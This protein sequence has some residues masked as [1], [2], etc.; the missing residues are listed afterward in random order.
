MTL[1]KSS[2]AEPFTDEQYE[3]I[4]D[5]VQIGI[6]AAKKCE[7]DKL[8]A[9]IEARGAKSRA[10]HAAELKAYQ[11][12]KAAAA[13]AK[14]MFAPPTITAGHITAQLLD[15]SFIK[16]EPNIESPFAKIISSFISNMVAAR[17]AAAKAKIDESK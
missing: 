12:A 14:S 8:M 3:I 7:H 1:L 6:A 5:M 11:D 16:E 10:H 2:K 17:V 4:E 9:E 13:A 15:T